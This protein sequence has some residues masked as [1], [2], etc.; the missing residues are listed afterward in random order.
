VINS[1]VE[2]ATIRS[3]DADDQLGIATVTSD[4]R[5]LEQDDGSRRPVPALARLAP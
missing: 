2:G 5:D 3:L 4:R 1:I